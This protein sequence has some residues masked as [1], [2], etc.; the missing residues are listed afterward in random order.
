MVYISLCRKIGQGKGG[1]VRLGCGFQF[2]I[3]Q[4]GKVMLEQ[5]LK[6]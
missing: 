6:R 1:E 4:S 5:K 3:G 2:S